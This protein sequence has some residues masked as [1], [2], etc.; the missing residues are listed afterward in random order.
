MLRFINQLFFSKKNNVN[1][2]TSNNNT[3]NNLTIINNN[4]NSNN[5]DNN[6]ASNLIDLIDNNASNLT[7][8]NHILIDSINNNASNLTPTDRILIDSI[9]NNASNLVTNNNF[10][11]M[12]SVANY[13]VEHSVPY[14]FPVEYAKCVSVYDGDTITILFKLTC[15]LTKNQIIYRHNVRLNGLDC[16]EMKDKKGERKTNRESEKK[17]AILAKK[18]VEELVL[19]KVIKLKNI[20]PHELYGR[21]LADVYVDDIHVNK[22]LLDERLAIPYD[23]KTKNVPN[24]W[25]IFHTAC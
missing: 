20:V 4:A 10:K 2:N 13:D 5:A 7:P 6:N 15:D 24:D 19:N 22:I 14:K 18:R 17:I 8:T 9:N 23:G 1:N 11:K 12:K 3:S 16:P 21:I 25:V